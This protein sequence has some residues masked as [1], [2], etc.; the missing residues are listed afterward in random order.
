MREMQ[1]IFS[2]TH[3]AYNRYDVTDDA[4]PTLRKIADWM[5]KRTSVTILVE[6]HCD[7]RGTN[8]YNLALGDQRAQATKSYLVSL[9]VSSSR[10]E[11]VSFGKEQPLCTEKTEECWTKNRRAHFVMSK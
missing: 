3:F 6:G 1:S 9:G 8:E 11:T 2:D 7:E 4:K 5:L 10:I